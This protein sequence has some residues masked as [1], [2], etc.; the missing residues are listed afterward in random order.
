MNARDG[1]DDAYILAVGRA[2]MQRGGQLQFAEA[3]PIEEGFKV[4][5]TLQASVNVALQKEIAHGRA[6]ALKLLLK[7]RSEI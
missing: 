3:E 4:T 5:A 1:Q 2:V 7:G 6:T